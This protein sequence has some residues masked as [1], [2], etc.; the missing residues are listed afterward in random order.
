LILVAA[1]VLGLTLAPVAFA[2]STQQVTVNGVVPVL[3]NLTVDT[4]NV[5]LTFTQS[6]YQANGTAFK[7]AVNATTFKVSSNS[8]WRLYVSANS[9][10]FS[11]NPSAGGQDPNKNCGDLS[12]SPI[13]A[14]NYFAVTTGTKD[15]AN[16]SPGGYNDTGHSVP[17]SYKLNTT[18]AGDP[19][20]TYT[21]VLTYTLMA[22]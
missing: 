10:K 15:I 16:G 13:T 3:M 19:P 4:N 17:V 22:Q 12:L 2:Q 20:G 5:L 8:R 18:L 21:L 14:G 7:E 11:F 6:D 9:Q 1:T